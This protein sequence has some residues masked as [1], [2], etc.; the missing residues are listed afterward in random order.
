MIFK[1]DGSHGELNGFLDRGSTLKGDLHFETSFRVDGEIVGQISSQGDLVIGEEGKAEGEI[2]VGKIFV[3]GTVK[4]K[5]QAFRKVQIAPGGRVYADID[6]PSLVIE[7]GGVFEGHCRM[8]RRSKMRP[9]AADGPKS[10][11][12]KMPAGEERKQPASQGGR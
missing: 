5:L 3:T 4:G 9:A 6:T 1:S 11:V 7:D 10:V 8:T 2:S 12:T